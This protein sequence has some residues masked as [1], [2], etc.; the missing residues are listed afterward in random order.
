MGNLFPLDFEF[1]TPDAGPTPGHLIV[2]GLEWGRTYRDHTCVAIVDAT[3]MRLVALR[4]TGA[5]SFGPT[6]DWLGALFD[7]WKPSVIHMDSAQNG[8][9]IEALQVNGFPVNAVELRQSVKMDYFFTLA[10]LLESRQFH[11][12]RDDALLTQMDAISV[13]ETASGVWLPDFP[14]R[15]V[16]TDVVTAVALAVHAVQFR[17]VAIRYV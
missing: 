14:W 3:A 17:G 9:N 5:A 15:Y 4:R 16:E 7:F 13:R 6:N 10:R 11:I 12:L 8:P 1:T 2:F